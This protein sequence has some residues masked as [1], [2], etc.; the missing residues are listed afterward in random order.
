MAGSTMRIPSYR[1]LSKSCFLAQTSTLASLRKL[2]SHKCLVRR[3]SNT[4]DRSNWWR[5]RFA[6][7]RH[8]SSFGETRSGPSNPKI[9]NDDIL[10]GDRLINCHVYGQCSQIDSRTQPKCPKVTFVR[11][12]PGQLS[13]KK[14]TAGSPAGWANCQHIAQFLLPPSG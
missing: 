2:R 14:V 8:L 12:W 5:P 7:S 11:I 4:L 6:Y 13:T 9:T 1:N 10:L 3:S